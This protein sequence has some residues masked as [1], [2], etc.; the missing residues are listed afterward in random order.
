MT[1]IAFGYKTK[2]DFAAAVA[3]DATRVEVVDPSIFPGACSGNVDFVARTLQSFVVTN[4]PKRSWFAAVK[5]TPKG[6]QVK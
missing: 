1:H 4:H 6:I 2:K 5:L 3:E